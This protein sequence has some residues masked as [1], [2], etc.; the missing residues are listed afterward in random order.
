MCGITGFI[1]FSGHDSEKAANRVKVMADV[2]AH[3]GPDEDGFFIDNH[4]AFGHKRLSIIDLSSGQQPMHSFDNTHHI[5]FNG[6]VYNYLEIQKELIN[7]GHQFKTQCDTE[8]ILYAYM[9]WGRA[10]VERFNGMFAFAIWNSKDRTLFAARDRVGKKPFYY[11][12]DGQ[13]FAFGSEL[14]SL[15]AGGFSQKKIDPR[16]L[17]CYLTF[18]YIPAPMTIFKDVKK[19]TAAHTLFLSNQE[20]IIKRYWQ[21]RFAEPAPQSMDEA[22]EAFEPLLLDA[23]K[24]RLMSEV[25]LGAFLSSGLDS[26]LV[27]SFMSEIMDKRVITN[28]IGFGNRK[29]SEIPGARMVA[30][31]LNT[32]HHEFVV[33]PK[34]GE[35]IF[36]IAE[37]LDEPFA[38]SSALPTWHVCRMA[39]KNVTVALSGDGGDEAFGGY[40]FRYTPHRFESAVKSKIPSILR[41]SVF[42]MMGSIYPATSKLPQFLRF[43][44]IL[45]NLSISD[46]EAYYNDLI[47]LRTDNRKKLYSSEFIGSLKGFDPS[48][49]IIPY[50]NQ[51]PGQ[52]ALSKAQN[53][54]IQF[55]MTD[56]VLVKADRMSMAHSLEVRNPLLDYRIIEFAATLPNELK[57]DKYKGKLLL[58]RLSSQRLP[59]KIQNLPKQGFSIPAASWLRNDLK[60]MA[61]S[62]MDNSN[63]IQNYLNRSFLDRLWNEHQSKAMDHSVLLWGLMMLGLWEDNFLD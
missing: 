38:D 4:T 22:C 24:C 41:S 40:T 3:R 48:E 54:D 14:K 20:F 31:H 59:E 57:L 49:L 30:D 61:R 32:K 58:R 18:G 7:L 11:A 53:T 12:W 39:R 44:T 10:C 36:Q 5:V 52:D 17:D 21:A 23:V 35:T 13:T 62:A 28:T 8:V 6:E 43:K 45:E 37:Y 9:E 56:D 60:S 46:A 42:S 55:Y 16:S 27:V 63:I 51:C 47:W 19:L 26:T 34:V 50:Y 33:D 15:L 25:P 2:I 29:F 1:A